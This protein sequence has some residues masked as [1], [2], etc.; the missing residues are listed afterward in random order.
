MFTVEEKLEAVEKRFKKTSKR[1]K[2]AR[3]II[4]QN[5]RIPKDEQKAI[6]QEIP[7]K[8]KTLEGL[9]TEL[10]KMGL[11]PPQEIDQAPEHP[12]LPQEPSPQIPEDIQ[13]PKEPEYATIEDL[14]LLKD[15]IKHLSAVLSGSNPPA[16]DEPEEDE[17]EDTIQPEDIDLIPTEELSIQDPSLTPKRVWFKP[18][19]IMYFDLTRQGIFSSYADADELGPL[20]KFKGNLSDFINIIADDYFIR[21][22]NIDIGL[23]PRYV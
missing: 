20:T 5:R 22:Y 17:D 14:N 3:Y 18:K 4:R 6:C 12:Q 8:P 13:P 7:I 21:N 19:T 1:Y 9:F 23:L 10:R 11:Y 2:A 16:P 15:S